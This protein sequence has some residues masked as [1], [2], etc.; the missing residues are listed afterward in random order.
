MEGFSFA[1]DFTKRSKH[2][3]KPNMVIDL[4][5]LAK[6]ATLK[7]RTGLDYSVKTRQ[8]QNVQ[9][10]P[11]RMARLQPVY[12]FS[13]CVSKP[14][15]T[16]GIAPHSVPARGSLTHPSRSA[17]ADLCNRVEPIFEHVLSS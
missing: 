3:N 15:S 6:M 12:L 4:L 1:F 8:Q 10:L 2:N 7:V 9:H 13:R 16:P 14:W 5:T 11:I 17:Y